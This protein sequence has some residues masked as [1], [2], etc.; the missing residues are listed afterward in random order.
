M[1]ISE[2]FASIQGESTYAGLPCVFVRTGGCN[3]S[4]SYCDTSYAREGGTELSVDYIIKEV[5]NFNTELVEI[6]GGEPLLQK[7]TPLLAEKLLRKNFNVLVETNGSLDISILP[8][9]SVAIM[10][11]KC[12]GS[13]MSDMMDWKN[14][15]KL[16]S[17]D[18]IKFVIQDRGDY[19]WSVEKI[20]QYKLENKKN[21]ILFS[22]VFSKLPPEN[23]VKWILE[24]RLK[25]RFQLQMHKYIWEPDRRGV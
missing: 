25:V 24:D 21:P 16:R 5:E 23:L 18:E 8:E 22:C 6:T 7:D 10:D 11:I 4:C 14:I 1:L 13:N 19:V 9:K 15:E 2:I 12:P 3:L 20:K 17:G